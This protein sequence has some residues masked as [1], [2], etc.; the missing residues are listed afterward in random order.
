MNLKCSLK[1]LNIYIEQYLHDRVALFPLKALRLKQHYFVHYP[2][3]KLAF[4][5]LN[6]L[7]TMRFKSKH[8]Y[9]RQCAINSQNYKELFKTLAFRHRCL[10]AYYACVSLFRRLI[11]VVD[12]ALSFECILFNICI[13]NCV[14]FINMTAENTLVANKV[15]FRNIQPKT[16]GC[17][18]WEWKRFVTREYPSSICSK[19]KLVVQIVQSY[20]LPSYSVHTY[21]PQSSSRSVIYKCIGSWIGKFYP[22]SPSLHVTEW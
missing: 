11:T 14:K 22:Y 10:Q 16:G 1:Y 17:C 8:S 4:G 18:W 2:E 9:F 20:H 15:W 6:H 12:L 3:L 21:D 19:R 13:Q 7:W 5:P